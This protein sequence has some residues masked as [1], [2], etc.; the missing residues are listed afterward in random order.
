MD[1]CQE[2]TKNISVFNGTNKEIVQ[3]PVLERSLSILSQFG[4]KWEY[5]VIII[6]LFMP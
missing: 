4:T 6:V 2:G 5:T 3:L 1:P